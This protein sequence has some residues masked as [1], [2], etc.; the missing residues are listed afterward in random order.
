MSAFFALL[1]IRRLGMLLGLACF[2]VVALP[3]QQ[4]AAQDGA[5][6]CCKGCGVCCGDGAIKGMMESA[7]RSAGVSA[8]VAEWAAEFVA[9]AKKFAFLAEIIKLYNDFDKLLGDKFTQVGALTIGGKQAQAELEIRLAEGVGQSLNNTGAAESVALV[10]G[11]LTPPTNDNQVLCN[12]VSIRQSVD[13]A[14]WWQ[15]SLGGKIANMILDRTR[16]KGGADTQYAAAEDTGILKAGLGDMNRCK[17]CDGN[18]PQ[19]AADVWKLRCDGVSGVK[20]ANPLDGFPARCIPAD[21][22]TIDA[23]ISAWVLDGT[24]ALQLPSLVTKTSFGV[25]VNVPVPKT[26][27]QQLYAAAV[28]FCAFLI[29]PRPSPPHGEDLKSPEGI[30]QTAEFDRSMVLTSTF[31]TQC[32]NR[33]AYLTR[34]NCDD[35]L[36]YADPSVKKVCDTGNKACK[37]YVANNG[38]LPPDIDPTGANKCPNGLSPRQM[39]WISRMMCKTHQYYTGAVGAG[40]NHGILTNYAAKCDLNIAEWESK[41]AKENLAFVDAVNG[42]MTMSEASSGRTLD[43]TSRISAPPAAPTPRLRHDASSKGGDGLVKKVAVKE[44]QAGELEAMP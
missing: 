1:S 38:T 27:E 33:I 20:T 18:G 9:F 43:K 35:P 31:L 37:A 19:Y 3:A 22:R 7:A 34:P 5:C 41:Q 2:L 39:E 42:L 23:D 12:V 25:T 26:F 10:A 32:T 8:Q 29:G 21:K 14:V 17:G 16:G 36:Q 15:K 44:P 11:D 13:S 24:N 4:V 28:N 30:V 6:V 40:V